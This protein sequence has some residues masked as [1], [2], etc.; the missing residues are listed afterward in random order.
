LN[1]FI[2]DRSALTPK[3]K[4]AT[5]IYGQSNKFPYASGHAQSQVSEVTRAQ[6]ESADSNQDSTII[7][8][9]MN[10]SL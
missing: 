8:M 5:Y 1:I 3:A 9:G 2:A 7:T 10:H 6:L 4:D